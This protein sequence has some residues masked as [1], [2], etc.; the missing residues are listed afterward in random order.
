MTYSTSWKDQ[1]IA[2]SSLQI[3]RNGILEAVESSLLEKQSAEKLIPSVAFEEVLIRSVKEFLNLHKRLGVD[4]P[5]FIMLT[6]VGVSG[7]L[8]SSGGDGFTRYDSQPIDREVLQVPEIV[9]ENYE[10]DPTRIL[11][12][13][14]DVVWNSAGFPRSMNYDQS[15]NWRKR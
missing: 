9:V 6:L 5:I 2:N 4:S 1:S 8:M 7:Y 10:A 11:Q 12:P 3:F 14:F 13:I 15:G